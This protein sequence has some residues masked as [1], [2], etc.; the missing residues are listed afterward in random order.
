MTNKLMIITDSTSDIRGEE[1][2]KL[3]VEVVP[4]G[5]S[6]GD[7]FY[8]EGVSISVEQF[9]E[10][11]KTFKG[12]PKTSQCSPAVFAELYEKAKA[13]GQEVLVLLLSSQLSGN[14]QS[15]RIAATIAEYEDHIHFMDTL[16]CLTALRL[17]VKTACR[18]RDQGMDVLTIVDKLEEMKSHIR[19]FAIVDT[20][21][22]FHKGGRLS[23]AAMI[24]GSLIGIKPFIDLDENGKIRNFGR[25]IGLKRGIKSAI[26][27]I[28]K[29]EYDPE[30]GLHYGYTTDE[31]IG[32]YIEKT[33]PHF[34]TTEYDNTRIGAAAG[35]H[36]GPGGIC[37]VYVSKNKEVVR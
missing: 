3:G 26:E 34:P 1:I 5:I 29:N 16:S 24:I 4:L 33:L 32:L 14:L 15:A 12:F 20:L 36:I 31:N 8:Q 22:Y 23:R 30:F 2:S 35:A 13:N 11:L 19:I 7:D 25:S 18:Y 6:F 28:K 17:I 9:Y 10:K 37:L 21:E 27:F